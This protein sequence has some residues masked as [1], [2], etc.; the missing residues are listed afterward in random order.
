MRRPGTETSEG[1]RCPPSPTSG[2]VRRLVDRAE[3]V[4]VSAALRHGIGWSEVATALGAAHD[5][6]RARWATS[7]FSNPQTTRSKRRVP[8]ETRAVR[9]TALMETEIS[10]SFVAAVAAL[11]SVVVAQ[12]LTAS[13]QVRLARLNARIARREEVRRLV[14]PLGRANAEAAVMLTDAVVALRFA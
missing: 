3:L 10:G 12:A 4:A 14:G 13:A 6:V 1:L 2:L 9:E 8:R 11:V 5:T 7:T